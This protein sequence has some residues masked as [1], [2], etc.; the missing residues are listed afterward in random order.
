MYSVNILK[1]C[2]FRVLV[3]TSYEALILAGMWSGQFQK[4]V[5]RS[6]SKF[7]SLS[8]LSLGIL[9]S[10][11]VPSKVG[12]RGGAAGNFLGRQPIRGDKTSLE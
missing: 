2:V 9:Y 1:C 5:R 4:G 3:S 11:F 6:S 8:L 12:L 7:F 10:N